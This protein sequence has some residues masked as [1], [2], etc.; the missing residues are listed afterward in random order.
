[1]AAAGSGGDS[2]SVLRKVKVGAEASLEDVIAVL[3]TEKATACGVVRANSG[4]SEELVGILTESDVVNGAFEG[5]A[6]HRLPS[7]TPVASLV[8]GGRLE[9]GV[10]REA[11]PTPEIFAQFAQQMGAAKSKHLPIVAAAT[12]AFL[13]IMTAPAAVKQIL[14]SDRSSEEW[15]AAATRSLD[16]EDSTTVVTIERT[17]TLADAVV[18]MRRGRKALVVTPVGDGG[19]RRMLGIITISDVCVLLLL[20]GIAVDITAVDTHSNN[21]QPQ[22]RADCGAASGRM[23]RGWRG[24]SGACR[25]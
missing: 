19:A 14:R 7:A 25:T 9:R 4:G 23:P 18:R 6:A 13:G 3:T 5:A 11:L 16:L 22:P 12:G 10:L 21:T 8:R 2:G 1:M 17:A 24:R 15:L 20:G